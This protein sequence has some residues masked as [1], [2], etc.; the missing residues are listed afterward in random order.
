MRRITSL[1]A[2]L[3]K[4]AAKKPAATG[5]LSLKVTLRNTKPPIWRQIQL[6]VSMTLADLHRAVQAAMGGYSCHLHDF[7]VGG[8][9]YGD[10]SNKDDFDDDIADESRLH[11][12]ALV[13]S[14]VTR[15]LYTYDYGDRWEHEIRIEKAPP[16]GPARASPTCV[17]G[18]RNC[19]PED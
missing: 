4:A 10:P 18:Q 12:N 1:E 3:A 8:T 6:P 15:F 17:A 16:A 19:P 5:V 2:T 13:K 7:D 9:R 11:L 14:G